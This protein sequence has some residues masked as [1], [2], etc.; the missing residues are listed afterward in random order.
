MYGKKRIYNARN[1]AFMLNMI[2]IVI[3]IVIV[4]LAI[5]CFLDPEKYIMLFPV[6]FFLAGALN[7]VNGFYRLQGSKRENKKKIA[8]ILQAV[9]G[10][11]LLI[12]TLVSGISIWRG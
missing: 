12:L 1:A 7:I 3:G 6:I 11:L 2:H 8:G 9:L 4:V 10:A 5:C